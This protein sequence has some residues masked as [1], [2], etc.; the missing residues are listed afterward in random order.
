MYILYVNNTLPLALALLRALQARVAAYCL[1][2]EYTLHTFSI[3]VWVSIQVCC[4]IGNRM[5]VC[6]V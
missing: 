1:H 2:I 4:T 6:V 3:T 5:V